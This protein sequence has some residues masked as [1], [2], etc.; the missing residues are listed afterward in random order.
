[1][2]PTVRHSVLTDWEA[3][4]ASVEETFGEP[5]KVD[6]FQAMAEVPGVFASVFSD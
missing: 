4:A 5:S 1:M 3:Y 6:H 2:P